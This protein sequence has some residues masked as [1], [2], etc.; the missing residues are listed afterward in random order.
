MRVLGTPRRDIPRRA[1]DI[2]KLRD[3]FQ[4]PAVGTGPNR[5]YDSDGRFLVVPVV[6]I[7]GAWEHL[8]GE[9]QAEDLRVTWFKELPRR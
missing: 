5:G 4:L 6:R 1:N 9:Y 8:Q 3:E 2:R 7:R